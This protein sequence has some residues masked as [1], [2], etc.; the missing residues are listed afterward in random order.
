MHMNDRCTSAPVLATFKELGV[1]LP[2][3]QMPGRRTKGGIVPTATTY[4]DWIKRQPVA[5]QNEILGSK[6]A[7]AMRSGRV[8]WDDLFDDKGRW[9]TLDDLKIKEAAPKETSVSA[10]PTRSQLISSQRY[11]DDDVV[12]EKRAAG[13]YTVTVSPEFEIDGKTV[14]VVLDGHHR[15]EAARLDGVKPKFVVASASTNDRIRALL[16]GDIETFLDSVHEGD[17]WYWLS[18]GKFVW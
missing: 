13:D 6:R 3:I 14:R 5:V 12:A 2:E 7:A 11:L 4:A 15:L 17:D 10:G 16:D 18:T 1:D 9:L 8:Q